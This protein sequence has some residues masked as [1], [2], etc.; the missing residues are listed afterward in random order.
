MSLRAST[1]EDSRV[2][3][4]FLGLTALRG[5]PFAVGILETGELR[6]SFFSSCTGHHTILSSDMMLSI[7]WTLINVKNRQNECGC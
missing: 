2:L 6:L 4:E 1:V 5:R 7:G 3:K